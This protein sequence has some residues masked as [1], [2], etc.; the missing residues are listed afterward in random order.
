MTFPPESP[1]ITFWWCTVHIHI[2]VYPNTNKIS[3]L[4]FATEEL[5]KCLG[6][7]LLNIVLRIHLYHITPC[8]RIRF[9]GRALKDVIYCIVI[10]NVSSNTREQYLI[11]TPIRPT[12]SARTSMFRC[13]SFQMQLLMLR[14]VSDI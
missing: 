7:H 11:Y 2:P 12:L 9:S 5:N 4:C 1:S 6:C 10:Q 3:E 13:E 8:A 14:H